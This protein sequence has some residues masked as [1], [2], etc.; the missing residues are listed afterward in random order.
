[1][2]QPSL[3]L[4]VRPSTVVKQQKILEVAT[5][6]FLEQGYR[7]TALDQIVQRCGGSKQTLYRYFGCKEGLFKAVLAHNLESL[8]D[9]F[10]FSEKA[11]LP[12][13]SCLVSFG[14]DY[15][16]RLCTNPVLGLYRI[17]AADFHQHADITDFFLANGP[18]KKHQYL[19]AY[20]A[21]DKVAQQLAILSPEQACCNLLA[22]LKQDFFYTTLL[23]KPLPDKKCLDQQIRQSVSAFIRMYQ[24]AR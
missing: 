4:A 21:S 14:Q 8:E 19:I 20:L 3:K 13:E 10:D 17:V 23:G 16:H 7:D 2:M 1:M 15:I 5:I 24:P 9:V 6:L 18:D 12:V 11:S 22:L